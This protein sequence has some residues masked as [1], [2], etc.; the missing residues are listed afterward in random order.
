MRD[1]INLAHGSGGTE[2][3][4]LIAGFGFRNRGDWKEYDNDSATIDIGGGQLLV[5]TTDSFIVDP[6]FFPGGDIGHL[7]VC[8]TI[9]DLAVM[10]AK[11]LGLSISLVLEEGFPRKDL[12]RIIKSIDKLSVETKIPI[13]T[14]DTKV[15]D[16][17]KVD[18]IVINT[19]GVGIAT[20]DGILTKKIA[21]GD[22]VLISGGL[23]EHAVALLSKRFDYE[24][25]VVSD[26]KPLIGELMS[27]RDRLKVAKDAT[28]GGIA[29]VLNEIAGRNGMGMLLI[30]EKVPVR[31]EVRNLAEML[32]IEAY[33][34]ASEGRFVCI[35]SA[36]DAPKVEKELK[37]FN[38]DAAIIGVIVKGDRV[39]IQTMLGR[40]ILT[41]PRGRI[42]PR[43]C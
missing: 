15:M 32:G 23:G 34:L 38:K 22:K 14:G 27:V 9:N 40:R 4:Q 16:R 3:D 26:S 28:R 19:A 35:A 31:K 41:K 33:E 2:M 11:P 20:K 7:A 1:V 36:K 8:G 30:E 42:V 39:A 6:I 5:F 25:N 29:A 43:I 13:A 18:K 10:G 21:V 37:R 12:S 17:G 24:T